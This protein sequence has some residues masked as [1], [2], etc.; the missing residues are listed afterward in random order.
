FNKL[1]VK[2]QDK[3]YLRLERLREIG[4]ELR[5]TRSRLPATRDLRTA[6]Q[7]S[8]S[9]SSDPL[10]F[11]RVGRSSGL[12]RPGEGA[13]GPAQ[14]NRSCCRAQETI[15]GVSTKAHLRGGLTWL[16]K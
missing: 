14:G 11:P 1:P 9:S 5:R 2:V 6:C 12:A 3:S 16:R 15:R 4:H 7:P 10:L 13:S 8:R